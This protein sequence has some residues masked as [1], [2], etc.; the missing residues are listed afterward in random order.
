MLR[1]DSCL[2]L[3]ACIQ[4]AGTLG[5]PVSVSFASLKW[6]HCR[7]AHSQRRRF[8]VAC[9]FEGSRCKIRR[10]ITLASEKGT[11]R[12]LRGEPG[13]RERQGACLPSTLY[14][15]LTKQPSSS[16]VPP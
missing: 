12:G 7:E 8:V 2:I 13:S 1:Q 3:E 4:L 10:P 9:G 15:V 11:R 6:R 5:S 16:L 14:E